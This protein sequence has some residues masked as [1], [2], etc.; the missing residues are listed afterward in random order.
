MLPYIELT[1]ALRRPVGIAQ[2]QVMQV[3]NR[4]VQYLVQ[5]L[6]VLRT[7]LMLIGDRLRKKSAPELRP[8]PASVTPFLEISCPDKLRASVAQ[9]PRLNS[10]LSLGPHG[11]HRLAYTEWGD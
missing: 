4:V 7:G 8:H 2:A 11:F 1:G 10:M 5:F 6:E 3:G 9:Q